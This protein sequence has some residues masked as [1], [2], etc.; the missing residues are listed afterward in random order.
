MGRHT[1]EIRVPSPEE[2]E[3]DRDRRVLAP[4]TPRFSERAPVTDPNIFDAPLASTP[5]TAVLEHPAPEVAPPTEGLHQVPAPTQDVS[6]AASVPPRTVQP[7]SGRDTAATE[8]IQRNLR[9]IAPRAV[10]P[11]NPPREVLLPPVRPLPSFTSA[12]LPE[13]GAE[14]L[15]SPDLTPAPRTYTAPAAAVEDVDG[16]VAAST[17]FRARRSMSLAVC[18]VAVLSAVSGAAVLLPSEG[19]IET[20][21]AVEK[22]P[23]SPVPVAKTGTAAN[24]HGKAVA[25]AAHKRAAARRAARHAAQP[26]ASPAPS[27]IGPT[28][29]PLGRR[30]TTTPTATPVASVDPRPSTTPSAQPSASWRSTPTA[31]PTSSSSATP[32]ATTPKPSSSAP[33]PSRTAAAPDRS[34][35]LRSLLGSGANGAALALAAGVYTFDD[36][37]SSMIGVDLSASGGIDGA[38]VDS[39]IVQMA[40]HSSSKAGSVPKTAWKTNPLYLLRFGGS[41]VLKDFTLKATAQGHLYNGMKLRST[42]N[43]RVTNVRVQ[44]VAG[45]DDIPPGE[46]FGINDA[47]THGSV[48][49]HVE[50]DGANLGASGFGANSSSDVTIRDGYFHDN[51]YGNGATFWQTKNVTVSDTTSSD[52]KDFAFNFERVSGTVRI[53][54]AV[55]KNNRQGDLRFASDQGSAKVTI[56][57]PVFSGSKLRI[58]VNANYLGGT[59]KQRMSDIRVLIGGVDKTDSVVQWIR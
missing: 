9:T 5:R 44:G 4:S 20:A 40:P 6:P 57:D 32:A 22:H 8:R 47:N 49:N 31:S 3:A 14:R 45:N 51:G 35:S 11:Q 10:A 36:F 56:V 38:G 39:T 29:S 13:D 33:G 26:S 46:T 24:A 23:T 37:A 15:T 43:A 19:A 42:T 50:V 30:S 16:E 55:M 58:K 52:N 48:Y 59:N 54:N 28:L 41:P 34:Y 53:T 18:A 7:R 12:P 21:G 17:G 1:A 27:T 25:A 2:I